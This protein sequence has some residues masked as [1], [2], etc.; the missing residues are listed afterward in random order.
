MLS[1]TQLAELESYLA[2]WSADC[3]Y[4]GAADRQA[5]EGRT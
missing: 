4:C 2:H 5:V 1:T 3:L